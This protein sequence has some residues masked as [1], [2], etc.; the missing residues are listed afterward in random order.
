MKFFYN[1]IKEKQNHYQL[2]C[3]FQNAW[4]SKDGWSK[5]SELKKQASQARNFSIG[6]IVEPTAWIIKQQDTL[7]DLSKRY[8][9]AYSGW[10]WEI[11]KMTDK[12]L[13]LKG[14][15]VDS[16]YPIVHIW[17][18]KSQVEM[19]IAKNGNPKVDALVTKYEQTLNK[20]EQNRKDRD[21]LTHR[22]NKIPYDVR[23]LERK[24]KNLNEKNSK[25]LKEFKES[26][27]GKKYNWRSVGEV[28]EARRR[29]EQLHPEIAQSR[30]ENDEL[31]KQIDLLKD[32]S[33]QLE[34]KIADIKQRVDEPLI[35]ELGRLEKQIMEASK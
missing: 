23:N 29:L 22:L 28:Q 30:R 18:P 5:L 15:N 10:T 3:F 4:M 21:E 35:I 8:P 25:L 24:Q 32:E 14:D 26:E 13:Y 7:R 12:A 34:K 19:N 9:A 17:C 11:E 20:L 6:E 16:A 33:K 2:I 27:E 31:Q 1:E